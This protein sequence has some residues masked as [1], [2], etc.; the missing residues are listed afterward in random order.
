MKNSLWWYLSLL[1]V[2][3]LVIFVVLPVLSVIFMLVV[4]AIA[5]AA[6]TFLAA[7]LLSKLPWFRDWIWVENYG[8][9]RVIRFGRRRQT[10]YQHRPGHENPY[11]SQRVDDGSVIDVEGREVPERKE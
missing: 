4:G 1:G 7:P 6:L 11:R 10:S 3:L 2:L 8:G 5:L 9:R